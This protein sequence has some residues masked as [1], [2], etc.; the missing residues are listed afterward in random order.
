LYPGE[1]D[2]TGLAAVDAH[3]PSTVLVSTDADPTSGTPLI[4]KADGKRHREL[5]RGRRAKSAEKW[6]WT[7]VTANSTA[8]NVRPVIP[9]WAGR[10]RA[11]LWLRGVMR[12]Y[13]DYDFEVA[14]IVERR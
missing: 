8:D 2:Y 6:A 13:T 7:P 12:S 4:S 3:D 5:F 11:V 9:I 10:R 1:D 14:G